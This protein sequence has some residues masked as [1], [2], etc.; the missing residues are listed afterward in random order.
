[1]KIGYDAK[2]AV[3]NNTGLGN[4]S[5]LVIEG[6]ASE[7]PGDRLL[8]YTPRFEHHQ[9][10]ER[11]ERLPNVDFR[12]PPPQG[13]KGTMWRTFGITNNLRADG[14][15]IYHGL[16]NELPLNIS[17]A[18]VPTVLT[19]HDVIYRKL[20]HDYSL[21]DRLLDDFK[22]GRSCRA[23]THIIAVSECTRRDV[24][25]AYGIDPEKISVVYQGCAEAF[26][27]KADP[28]EIEALRRQ[29]NLPRRYIL[30]VGTIEPRKNLELTVRALASL[31][32]DIDLVAVGRERLGYRRKVERIAEE[33]GVRSRVHFLEGLEGGAIPLLNQGA[34]IIAYPSRYEGFGI[35]VLEGITSGRP[36]VAATGSCLEEAGGEGALYVS[37]DSP[38]E[39]ANALNSILRAET[40]VRELIRKGEKH[41]ARFNISDVASGVRDVYEKVVDKFFSEKSQKASSKL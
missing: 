37:P 39:M 13:F 6:I 32:E 15:D 14:V 25:E 10:T 8:L 12:L 35:P 1:M 7:N 28:A 3:F 16:S 36:V 24:A 26:R 31:P 11:M 19:M 33:S 41:A 18:S 5:R 27:K 2:R 38:R 34:E 4:Y 30:Q 20:P 22:Y 9:R 29:L 40:D 17:S 23:A 21:A